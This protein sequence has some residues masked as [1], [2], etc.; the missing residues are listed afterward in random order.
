MHEEPKEEAGKEAH[1]ATGR[2][3]HK[4]KRRQFFLS[5]SSFS[6]AVQV[7]APGSV[8]L[9]LRLALVQTWFISLPQ[10]GNSSPHWFL[11]ALLISSALSDDSPSQSYLPVRKLLFFFLKK[12]KGKKKKMLS[13]SAWI[14][15]VWRCDYQRWYQATSP[16]AVKMLPADMPLGCDFV[17]QNLNPISWGERFHVLSFV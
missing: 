3:L 6:H 10:T 8:S 15:L 4:G 5:W 11:F 17:W 13:F 16:N 7:T 9:N 14:P 2:T 12:G 1:L